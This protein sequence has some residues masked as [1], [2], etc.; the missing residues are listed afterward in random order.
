MPESKS[1]YRL[2]PAVM[3]I[4]FIVSFANT[5]SLLLPGIYTLVLLLC[6][7]RAQKIRLCPLDI[8]ILCL[9][10]WETALGIFTEG[11]NNCID[12]L[13][14]Q[15]I[16]TA[17][18]FSLRLGLTGK[19]EVQKFLQILF[20]FTSAISIISLI[21]FNIFQNKIYSAGFDSLYD[22]KHLYRPLGNLNNV[23]GTLLLILSG[24][25]VIPLM[26][27]SG[28]KKVP[29]LNILTLGLLVT[30]LVFSFSRGIYICT[31]LTVLLMLA[32]II[33]SGCNTKSKIIRCAVILA[34][35][36]GVSLIHSGDTLRTIKFVETA[37]QRK[38]LE[39]RINTLEYIGEAFQKN[40]VTGVGTGNWSLA[41]DEYTHSDGND[42]YT[43]FAPNVISQLIVEKGIVGTIL[44]GLVYILEFAMIFRY[45][46]FNKRI[47]IFIF[48][49]LIVILVR[50]ASFAAI[51]TDTR[52]LAAV[53]ILLALSMNNIAY[54]PGPAITVKRSV[55]IISTVATFCGLG[56]YHYI[57]QH[58]RKCYQ[59][60]CTD[61]SR[62][63]LPS[64]YLDL[65]KARNNVVTNVLAS[66]VSL[67]MYC[68]SNDRQY[69]TQAKDHIERAISLS[70]EDATLISFHAAVQQY[71]QNTGEALRE[72]D[73]LISRFPGNS[74]YRLMMAESLYYSGE[75]KD[76]IPHFARAAISSP[77]ILE[78]EWWKTFTE[79]DRETGDAII[80][81]IRSGI[82]QKPEDPMLLSKYGKLLYLCGDMDTA[83]NYLQEASMQLPSLKTPWV[84]LAKIAGTETD[85]K[86][87]QYLSLWGLSK[88]G[89]ILKES[90][91]EE[92]TDYSK[93][94]I[95]SNQWYGYMLY[96]TTD[97]SICNFNDH[98]NQLNDT[99][100]D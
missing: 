66:S 42:S 44:W 75:K 85:P 88:N 25:A 14:G 9:L 99:N 70:P 62:E 33:F 100:H 65:K 23:W 98:K 7:S 97:F 40:P 22:F 27:S 15:Y 68:K 60:Y 79:Y 61:I 78:S 54:N 19:Y 63:D 84:Y 17:Y 32:Y 81:G 30:C 46:F 1:T 5:G 38:S 90:D 93:Y 36:S 29:V 55:C 12:Y 67:E 57:F 41:T 47:Q 11:R 52:L 37:S 86:I 18:Y 13:T 92:D 8:T 87:V 58:D 73:S 34:F 80:S 48:L 43:N 4:L 10:L 51:L 95:K 28:Q 26:S 3:A 35:M 39:G 83:E 45:R 72:L 71:L 6:L 82:S 89:N 96:H 94:D 56:T 16:F 24:I 59:E 53:S 2:M 21:S 49:F 76:A 91:K 77:S 31:G 50:E 64:A 74:S 20:I 69:L